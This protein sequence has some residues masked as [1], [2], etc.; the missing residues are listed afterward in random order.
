MNPSRSMDIFDNRIT[1]QIAFR[2]IE[3]ISKSVFAELGI[4]LLWLFEVERLFSGF[5]K[6]FFDTWT[7]MNS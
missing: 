2:N 7:F 6:Y 5:R 4:D 1:R 3:K